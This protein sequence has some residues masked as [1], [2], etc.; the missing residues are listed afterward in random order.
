MHRSSTFLRSRPDIAV[1]LLI[2]LSVIFAC[3]FILLIAEV[4]E[5][6]LTA[7]DQYGLPEVQENTGS[8]SVSA[9]KAI[10]IV[11]SEYVVDL[12]TLAIS[13]G[14]FLRRRRADAVFVAA[15]I[16][17]TYPLMSLI[18]PAVGRLRPLMY[19]R[20]PLGRDYYGFPS[21][22]TLD[23]TCLMLALC[24]LLWR[25]GSN[26]RIKG[27]GTTVLIGWIGIIS[28]SRV[29]L[30]V[31]YPTDVLG[32]AVLGCAWLAALAALRLAVDWWLIRGSS[33]RKTLKEVRHAHKASCPT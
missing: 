18:K 27:I 2:L 26:I 29:V 16:A 1:A 7:V 28:L 25:G 15:A 6:G 23:A 21:G 12:A 5:R 19:V 32:G 31:H 22:H 3:C 9:A 20:I 8:R 4:R 14:L 17:G 33:G 30:G 11:G 13:I 24:F 10:A